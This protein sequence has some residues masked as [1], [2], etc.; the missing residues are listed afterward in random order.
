MRARVSPFVVL[1][2]NFAHNREHGFDV[3]FQQGACDVDWILRLAGCC[4]YLNQAFLLCPRL[5]SIGV[6]ETIAHG[7]E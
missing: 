1:A 4:L 6:V 7:I 5:L 3:R 2:V